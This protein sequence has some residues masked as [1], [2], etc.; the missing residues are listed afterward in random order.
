[1]LAAVASPSPH[2]DEASRFHDLELSWSS[3][4][5]SYMSAQVKIFLR[6]VSVAVRV[7]RCARAC[8]VSSAADPLL[9]VP[10]EG[11]ELI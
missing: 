8:Q 7:C 5:C 9:A 10:P 1:M 11:A 2:H 4:R 6:T 3:Y